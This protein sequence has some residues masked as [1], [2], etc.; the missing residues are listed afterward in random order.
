M[1]VKRLQDP[2]TEL[3]S[4]LVF[5]LNASLGNDTEPSLLL[6]ATLASVKSIRQVVILVLSLYPVSKC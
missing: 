6:T 5:C 2:H 1:Y 3:T 4:T